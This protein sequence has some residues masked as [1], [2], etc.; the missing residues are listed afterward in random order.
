MKRDAVLIFITLLGSIFCWW[1]LAQNLGIKF[2]W[3]IV[4]VPIVLV[5]LGTG[6]ATTLSYRAWPYLLAGSFA[7]TLGGIITGALLI[8]PSPDAISNA[9]TAFFI[10]PI[11]AVTTLLSVGAAL[12]GRRMSVT[13]LHSRRAI[14]AALI[15]YCAFG[16]ALILL[17]PS[18]VPTLVAHNDRIARE[19]FDALKSAVVRTAA[20]DSGFLQTCDGSALSS[21]YSGPR[22][23]RSDWDHIA[24]KDGVQPRGIAEE[25]GYNY[26]VACYEN[27]A[28]A[29]TAR[30]ITPNGEG[31]LL[32]CADQTQRP[33]CG[34]EFDGVKRVC[35]PC[36]D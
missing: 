28:Y 2:P 8:W 14:W 15:A 33:T 3:W 12:A 26:I 32:L 35:K 17:T 34:I 30:P 22:F 4:F 19:R 27:G 16:P 6:L 7:G 31:T 36:A 11:T 29:I 5:A 23:S 25:A 24:G 20:E 21:R 9:M 1:A 13:D 10:L 18:L